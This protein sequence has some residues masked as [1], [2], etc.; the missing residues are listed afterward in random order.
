MDLREAYDTVDHR[1][2]VEVLEV[3]RFPI[4]LIATIKNLCRC[5]NTRVTTR[6]KN[7]NETSNTISFERGLPHGDAL[8]TLY[9]NPLKWKLSATEGYMISNPIN[10]KITDVLYID[11]SKV[12]AQ[13]ESRLSCVLK[14]TNSCMNDVGLQLNPKKSN[15]SI[16][17]RGEMK[18][19]ISG[20]KVS[21]TVMV[22]PLEED[23]Q[24]K[25]LG[26]LENV[27]QEQRRSLECAEKTYLRL[28]IIWS[29][30]LSDANR[31]VASN[32]QALAVLKY[33]ICTQHW[34]LTGLRKTDQEARKIMVKKKKNEEST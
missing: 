18:H 23:S 2:L 5:W 8:F 1:Y 31:V 29:S 25:F 34:P 30:P 6:T 15:A 20:I 17:K 13:S 21:D 3:H 28:S 26:I 7:G 16:V 24:Y 4:W 10:A 33:S 9:L 11:D 12:Y 19:E 22:Q 32:Q 14:D 27:R